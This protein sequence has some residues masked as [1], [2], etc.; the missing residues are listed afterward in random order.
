[1]VL[2]DV[3]RRLASQ[4]P[5]R[6][7][8]LDA[9]NAALAGELAELGS[10]SQG[11]DRNAYRGA[12]TLWFLNSGKRSGDANDEDEELNALAKIRRRGVDSVPLL[13]ALLDDDYLTAL[14]SWKMGG[15]SRSSYGWDMKLTEE[16]VKEHYL[17]MWRPLTRGDIAHRLLN[18]IPIS[19][20]DQSYG[21][22]R[23]DKDEL[24][25]LCE[26]WYQ[27]NKDKT[28]IELARLYLGSS[29]SSQQSD[30]L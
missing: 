11:L 24:R 1:M 12:R 29:N 4:E 21:F 15:I 14:D 9:E 25:M 5:P 26:E 22:E 10:K 13:L 27:E 28:A 6:I 16:M 3:N 30:A 19:S 8:G 17:S 23:K 7:E 20:G 18:Y 2:D